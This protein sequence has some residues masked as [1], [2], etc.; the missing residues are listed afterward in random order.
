MFALIL[1]CDFSLT[2]DRAYSAYHI[3]LP[4]LNVN[5]TYSNIFITAKIHFSLPSVIIPLG[6]FKFV[7]LEFTYSIQGICLF[8]LLLKASVTRHLLL[9]GLANQTYTN[10]FNIQ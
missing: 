3:K 6:I 8:R 10:I 5:V 2:N 7:H 9:K 1:A 4:H